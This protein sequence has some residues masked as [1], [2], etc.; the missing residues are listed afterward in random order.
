ME[1]GSIV[2]ALLSVFS[3]LSRV[4]EVLPYENLERCENHR[5]NPTP[6]PPLM[7]RNHSLAGKWVGLQI[8]V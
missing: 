4:D 3:L 1:N 8:G 5:A 7:S 2:S 6:P